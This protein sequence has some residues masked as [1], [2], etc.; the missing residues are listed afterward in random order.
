MITLANREK[1]TAIFSKL[2]KSGRAEFIALYGRRRVGKTYLIQSYF[3]NKGTYFEATGIR[4]GKMV[5]QLDL[6]ASA[7]EKHFNDNIPI[8]RPANWQAAFKLLTLAILNAPKNKPVII[9][10]DEL[11]WLATKRSKFINMLDHFWNSEWKNIPNLKLIICGSAA[12]WM[13]K[14]IVN[15]KGGLHNRLTK[16][17]LLEPFTLSQTHQFL[18]NKKMKLSQKNTLDIY[19]VTGGIPFYLDAL[20]KS[21]S[22]TQNINQLCFS[23]NGLL[24]D[25]FDRLF[26]SLFSNHQT[27][28]QIV[29]TI[30][31]K[32]TGVSRDE[33]IA[34]T[35]FTSGGTLNERLDELEAAGFIKGYIPFGKGKKYISYRVVDEYCLFYL[36]WIAPHKNSGFNFPDRY[37]ESLSNSPGHNAWAGYSFESICMKHLQ[38]IINAMAL[39]N[40]MAMPSTWRHIPKK[41]SKDNGSQID[42]LFDRSDD[43]ISVIEIKYRNQKYQLDKAS[44]KKLD[45]KIDVFKKVTKTKKQVFTILMTTVGV[46]PSLWLDDVVDQVLTLEDLF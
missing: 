42:L 1:E 7:Y 17:I 41:H 4:K 24:I 20:V 25:E 9:F 21:K 44:A 5:D 3:K 10:F 14:K 19:M 36:K 45:Q 31:K 12:S 29:T 38:K 37:W 35:G 28:T 30:A 34:T 43:A 15:D 8:A 39:G 6:F 16:T 23:K 46:K 26:Q 2:L 22:V 33:I 11:P 32:R 27:H 40:V 18:L 13:I